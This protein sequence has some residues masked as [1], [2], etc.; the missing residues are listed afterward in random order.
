MRNPICQ[1]NE[2]YNDYIELHGKR[3]KKK[4]PIRLIENALD[5]QEYGYDDK[6]VVAY[7]NGGY[8]LI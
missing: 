4:W 5:Y 1:V 3:A 8:K 2:D 6:W 7:I